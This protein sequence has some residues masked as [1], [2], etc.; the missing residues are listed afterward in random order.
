MNKIILCSLAE[1]KNVMNF[2]QFY[3]SVFFVIMWRIYD[4]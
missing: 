2:E 3:F 4:I 1:N